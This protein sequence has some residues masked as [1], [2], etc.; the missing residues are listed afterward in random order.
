MS[1]LD[2]RFV[3]AQRPPGA[4]AVATGIYQ[5]LLT[6]SLYSR[7]AMFPSDSQLFDE[8]ARD[9]G[10]VTAA[11]LGISRLFLEEEASPEILPPLFADRRLRWLD[12]PA[13]NSVCAP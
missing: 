10:A 9:C 11:V 12:R 13:A 5:N 7:C 8:R 4:R 1:A 2:A 3:A 6:R